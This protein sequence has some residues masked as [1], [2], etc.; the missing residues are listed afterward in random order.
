MIPT[1]TVLTY[2]E[3]VEKIRTVIDILTEA[4]TKFTST[5]DRKIYDK[6]IITLQYI[7]IE[8]LDE[9]NSVYKTNKPKPDTTCGALSWTT[10][11]GKSPYKRHYGKTLS[12]MD[13]L[14]SKYI[15]NSSA[16]STA[17]HNPDSSTST[18][19][20]ASKQV[21]VTPEEPGNCCN[22]DDWCNMQHNDLSSVVIAGK[23]YKELYKF[24]ESH[25]VNL[26]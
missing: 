7:C 23:L 18:I 24:I 13:L 4:Q 10:T 8:T 12:D 11:C 20:V 22:D 26:F 3:I 14:I 16:V 21:I 2:C 9:H 17:P 1:P 25:P 5:I 19:T 6:D 15:P